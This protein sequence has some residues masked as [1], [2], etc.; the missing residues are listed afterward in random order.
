MIVLEE[1]KCCMH[2][3]PEHFA[4]EPKLLSCGHPVC[5]MCIEYKTND[6]DE[7]KCSRCN[8]VNSLDPVSFIGF[9]YGKYDWIIFAKKALYGQIT[10]AENEI[11]GDR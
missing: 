5:Q 11:T 10:N 1:L 9:K 3:L 4:K 2:D 8:N 7:I 6:D